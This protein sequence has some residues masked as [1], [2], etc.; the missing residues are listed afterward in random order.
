MMD[1]AHLPDDGSGMFHYMPRLRTV[2]VIEP[3]RFA[4]AATGQLNTLPHRRTIR[5]IGILYK[6]AVLVTLD[7]VDEL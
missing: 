4:L 2:E 5:T 3:R 6:F 1:L 7:V